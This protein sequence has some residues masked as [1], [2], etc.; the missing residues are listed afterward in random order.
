MN[1]TNRSKTGTYLIL[2]L[3]VAIFIS[4]DGP[5]VQDKKLTSREYILLEEQLMDFQDSIPRVHIQISG[6]DGVDTVFVTPSEAYPSQ[7]GTWT[8]T[9]IP[10]SSDFIS[11]GK[12]ILEIPF[13]F[14]PNQ[15]SWTY[16]QI[17]N[18]DQRGFVKVR[19]SNPATGIQLAKRSRLPFSYNIVAT[20][21]GEPPVIGDTITFTYG[22][23][24]GSLSGKATSNVHATYYEFRMLADKTGSNSWNIITPIPAIQVVN[25]SAKH[26]QITVPS[27][28]TIEESVSAVFVAFDEYNNIDTEYSGTLE[29]TCF[30]GSDCGTQ[31]TVEFDL[32]D[33]GRVVISFQS[34]EGE[35]QLLAKDFSG[36][37]YFSNPYR[38]S[39]SPPEY[40]LYWGDI[41]NHTNIS[42]GNGTIEDFYNYAK[43]IA[44][45]DFVA[46]TDHDHTYGVNYLTPGVWEKIREFAKAH[47]S[48]GKFVSFLGWEWTNESRGHKHII[49]PGDD[50]EPYNNKTYP[51]ASDLW[52]AL[53][54]QRALTIPHH[55]AW[56]SRK[57]D[58]TFRSDEFQ[59]LVEIYSQHGANEFHLNPLDH[60]SSA[61]RAPGHYVRDALAMGHKT[62]IIAS[63]DGHFG[64]PGYGWMWAPTALDFTS[65][66]TGLTGVY[67]NDLSRETLFEAIKARRVFG[68][69]DHRTIV[70]FKVNN[71][72]M[73]SEISSDSL[74]LI[75]GSVLSHTPIRNVEIV[76]FNG[77]SYEITALGLDGTNLS[78][79]FSYRDSLYVRSS[80][81]YLRVTSVGNANDRFAWSSPVWVDKPM[82][83]ELVELPVTDEYLYSPES[84][85]SYQ[86]E[87]GFS[88]RS[89]A[90]PFSVGDILNFEAYNI[91]ESDEVSVFVNGIFLS[92]LET[93]GANNWGTTGSITI[94]KYLVD[95]LNVIRFENTN[96]LLSSGLSNWGVRK[97]NM[98]SKPVGVSSGRTGIII[99]YELKQNFPNP[100]NPVTTIDYALPSRSEVSLIIFDLRG[101]EVARLVDE[102]KPVGLHSARWDAS[103]VASGIY[104]Y[105][106]TADSPAGGFMQT[107]KMVLLK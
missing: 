24:S 2:S 50:G 22:D 30:G 72:W 59:R 74:P 99:S 71:A 39:M 104:L 81:Y 12:L 87:I 6:S 91:R 21:S 46:L 25:N 42:D 29:V 10:I 23:I 55:I 102:E 31:N 90:I 95:T 16:P 35:H 98:S 47:N 79:D 85:S 48:E 36:T 19:S 17:N 43:N 52:T 61:G 65:R 78:F 107:R 8:F 49:Y 67:A 28:L 96:A 38:V 60:L 105:R 18:P 34:G 89:D 20:F 93:T 58:W 64:Y 54:G 103:N 106:L 73:G 56:G 14:L 26:F 68:T 88:F 33:S 40:N 45:L 53:E 83:P 94:P 92:Y 86:Y 100:F 41:Q 51:L 76:K 44:N 75:K 13:A 62:G 63:S 77:M 1:K 7:K 9:Y 82:L 5:V 15:K 11:G 4:F 70:E 66:G 84:N 80:F 101:R 97:L 57:V 37:E 32:T 3:S 27:L 69:T